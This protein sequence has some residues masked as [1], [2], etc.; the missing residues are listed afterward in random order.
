MSYVYLLDVR[1]ITTVFSKSF[2]LLD[3]AIPV[4]EF[5]ILLLFKMVIVLLVMVLLWHTVNL[6]TNLRKQ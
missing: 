3:C 4:E 2:K 5:A 1:R 6:H